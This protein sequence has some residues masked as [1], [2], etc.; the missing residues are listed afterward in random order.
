MRVSKMTRICMTVFFLVAAPVVLF[1]AE[2]L[3]R[4][5]AVV[6]NEVIT[7]HE[8]NT[9]IRE[10]TGMTPVEL[11]DKNEKAFLD[12]RQQIIELMID[13]KITEAKIKELSIKV[14]Q[15]QVDEAIERMKS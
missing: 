12:A 15:K 6:N 1:A 9:R 14:S 8:L 5:V 13:E 10:M 4:I 11:K 3:N 7:L 2:P